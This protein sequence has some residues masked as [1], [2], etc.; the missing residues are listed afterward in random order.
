MPVSMEF[1]RGVLGLIGIACAYMMGRSLAAV[2][3]GWQR[4]SR[5][6]G[7]MIR[8]VLCLGALTIRHPIDIGDIVV[9]GIA[10]AAYGIALWTA[11]REKPQEDLT[12]TIFPEKE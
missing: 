7:W 4:P 11:S 9:W 5:L 10:A 6:Y 8:T 1:L 3:K 12:D 2:R